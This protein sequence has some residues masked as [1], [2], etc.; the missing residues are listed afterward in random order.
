MKDLHRA[1]WMLPFTLVTVTF[2]AWISFPAQDSRAR[3][4]GLTSWLARL[5][6]A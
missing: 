1:L 3:T 2:W 4:A 6:A 5:L